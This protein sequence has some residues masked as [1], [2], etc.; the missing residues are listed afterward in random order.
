[1]KRKYLRIIYI[2]IAIFLTT[3]ISVYAEEQ[4]VVKYDFYQIEGLL[5]ASQ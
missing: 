3:S 5:T 4:T 2:L 1:M